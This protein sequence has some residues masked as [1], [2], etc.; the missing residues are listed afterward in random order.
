MAMAGRRWERDRKLTCLFVGHGRVVTAP[1]AGGRDEATRAAA[2]AAIDCW[3]WSGFKGEKDRL[4]MG[5]PNQR[6]LYQVW[7]GSNVRHDTIISPLS[8][9]HYF[10]LKIFLQPAIFV[11]IILVKFR[12]I[13]F[14]FTL[15]DDR[16]LCFLHFF[17]FQKFLCG[18][19]L[20]FGPDAGSLFLSTVLIVA[21]LV[22]LCCQ[23]ITKM[24][25]ISSEKQVLG[26][27][28]LIATIV[29]GLAVSHKFWNSAIIT[30]NY[31]CLFVWIICHNCSCFFLS[32]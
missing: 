16:Q 24:N 30:T 11:V 2:A 13:F 22:G 10:S 23:C 9:F 26:L 8:S 25:S 14:L 12:S 1:A 3:C 4:F 7:Q 17:L 31:S 15:W 27:P 32:E 19:R 5:E 6:R 28:V 18:G 29:L 21:P 20:I